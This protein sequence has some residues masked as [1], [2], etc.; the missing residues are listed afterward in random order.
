MKT[1]M[2]EMIE[3]ATN[4]TQLFTPSKTTVLIK[5]AELLKKEKQQIKD[6]Y[7]L[8]FYDRGADEEDQEFKSSEDYYNET[9][10]P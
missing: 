2:Q 5:A 1:A 8:G 3:W 6:A 10:K 9:F 4:H 7:N